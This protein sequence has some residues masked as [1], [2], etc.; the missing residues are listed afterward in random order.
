MTYKETLFFIA[1]CLTISLE[2]K[3]KEGVLLKLQT[4]EIDWE[5]V[6]EVSTGHYVF[7]AL[8]CNLKRVEFLKYLPKDLVGYMKYLNDLNQ[9]RNTQ[10]ITQ[11]KELNKLLLAN[12]STP[13]FL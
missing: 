6:V 5:A 11:A 3:N 7:S 13:I 9:E 1:Q 8:Y 2:E 4:E 10:I 12:T